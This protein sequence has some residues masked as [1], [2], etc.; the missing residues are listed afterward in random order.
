MTVFTLRPGRVLTVVKDGRAQI[1]LHTMQN[2]PQ[3]W[4]SPRPSASS[5]IAAQTA[6]RWGQHPADAPQYIIFS[7]NGMGEIRWS[8]ELTNP[9]WSCDQ[10]SQDAIDY[11]FIRTETA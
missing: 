2:T 10:S 1:A 5:Y 8:V 7:I 6:H 9:G 4:W 11:F 3:V